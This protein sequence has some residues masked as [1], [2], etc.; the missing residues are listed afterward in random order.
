MLIIIDNRQ[1]TVEKKTTTTTMTIMKDIT[2]IKL[3][4]AWEDSNN[5]IFYLP[6]IQMSTYK[7]IECCELTWP[8]NYCACCELILMYLYKFI[9]YKSNVQ[10]EV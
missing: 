7:N 8:T 6:C 5:I 4:I 10:Y 9:S 1:P 2:K 3:L